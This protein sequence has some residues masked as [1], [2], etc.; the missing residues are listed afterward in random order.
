MVK[1]NFLKYLNKGDSRTVRAKKN[2]ILSFFLKGISI[3]I[4]LQIVPI[5][6]HYVNPT[7][8]GVW[9]TLSSLVSWFSFFDI[10]LTHGFRN[11]FAESKALGDVEGA[12]IYVSTTYVALFIVFVI[13]ISLILI[14]NTFLNWSDL[15]NIDQGYSEELNH[16]F[17]IVAFCFGV[18]IVASVFTTM[19]V[20]DQRPAIASFIQVMGQFVSFVTI[21][22]LTKLTVGNLSSL[23]LT[24]SGIPVLILVISS[25]V[26]YK[27]Q[28]KIYAPQLKFVRFSYLKNILGLGGQFFFIITSMLFIFQLMNIIISRVQ[29]PEVVTQYN[30]AYRF[31]NVLLMVVVIVLNPFWSAFTEAYAKRDYNWMRS[32][33]KKL[34]LLG[35]L[36]I[37][38]LGIMI[39]TSSF[40]YEIWLGSLIEIPFGLTVSVAVYILFQI[41]GNIYMINGT[42]KVRIQLIVYIVFAIISYPI[43]TFMCEKWGVMGI[44]VL[45]T[46]VYIIQGVVGCM[47]LNRLI[48]NRA[49]GI[50][51]K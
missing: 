41:F 48:N 6:I 49:I 20:A 34:E 16:V 45:P 47:Q 15:L 10:G 11:R 26:L 3:L 7:R 46:L 19:L 32:V 1:N 12:K 44:L 50:W 21:Y 38:L 2:I 29:G 25:I 43:M 14:L 24:F 23:A 13:F 51:N 18:N 30:L 9:L 22:V 8:Y 31:F 5:T 17:F 40:F 39:L 35:V 37:P 42:G 28:Y 36:S 4:S 27:T 33:R